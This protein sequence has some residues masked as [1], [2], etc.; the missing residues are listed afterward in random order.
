MIDGQTPKWIDRLERLMPG[1]GIPN[2]ALY[3]VGAQ[4]LGFLL[5]LANPRALGL[6]IL[7]PYSVLHGEL[8]RL[9]TFLAVPP[10]LSPLWMVVA[11]WFLYFI[12]NAIEQEWGEFRT[13]LY[14]L[15]AVI[16]TIAFSFVFSAPI[17]SVPEL[18]S[19]LFLA[20]ATI[21]PEF[22]ILLFFILPV[23]MKW[24]AWLSVAYIIWS[25]IFNSW[26]GRLYLLAMYANYLL[27]FGPYFVDRLKAF[28]R[29]RKFQQDVAAGRGSEE[30]THE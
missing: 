29:R 18:Q 30:E 22:Q 16:L 8:W 14:V 11:L 4:G 1:L 17:G 25:L 23:K 24:L 7:D 21:A 2:L 19:T 15:V 27:F 28:R 10:P 6:L 3:L 26:L 13:T 5:L 12:V 9:I 20:A